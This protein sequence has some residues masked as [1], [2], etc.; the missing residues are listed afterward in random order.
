MKTEHGMRTFDLRHIVDNMRGSVMLEYVVITSVVALG[1]AGFVY[2]DGKYVPLLGGSLKGTA[3][4][5]LYIDSE[6]MKYSSAPEADRSN[7]QYGLVCDSYAAQI[8][9]SLRLIAS[10]LP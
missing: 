2:A 10:P 6:Q 5:P 3:R 8:R 9:K 4:S 1:V 7:I